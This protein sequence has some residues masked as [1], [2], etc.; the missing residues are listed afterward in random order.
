MNKPKTVSLPDVTC[1]SHTD[2]AI[3]CL[4]QDRELWIPRS[5]LDLQESEV[6][7]TGHHG[8]LVVH[9]WFAE[10]EGLAG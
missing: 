6:V 2:L 5:A 3:Q 9:A 10:K 8:T 7:Q 1:I 4:V